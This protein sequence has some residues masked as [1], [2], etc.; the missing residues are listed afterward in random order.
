MSRGNDVQ[1]AE[2]TQA[3][4]LGVGTVVTFY[5]SENH[6]SPTFGNPEPPSL[7]LTGSHPVPPVGSCAGEKNKERLG[8]SPRNA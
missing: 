4:D 1:L 2:V 6:H 5:F 7:R 8:E 3:V